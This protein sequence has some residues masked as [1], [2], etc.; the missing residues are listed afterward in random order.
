MIAIVLC[1]RRWRGERFICP[2]HL[3]Q[4]AGG[5]HGNRLPRPKAGCASQALGSKLNRMNLFR[6]F[7]ADKETPKKLETHTLQSTEELGR[8]NSLRSGCCGELKPSCFAAL[9]AAAGWPRWAF[10]PARAEKGRSSKVCE[11][12]WPPGRTEQESSTLASKHACF[13]QWCRPSGRPCEDVAEAFSA[14]PRCRRRPLPADP[15]GWL[16]WSPL[17]S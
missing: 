16:W 1:R 17:H 3:C 12:V 13:R 14:C 4:R 2:V 7:R 10:E 6:P 11:F 5:G 8:S 9:A 15:L